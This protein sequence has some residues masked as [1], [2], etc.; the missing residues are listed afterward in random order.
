MLNVYLRDNPVHIIFIVSIIVYE[1]F[2]LAINSYS[3]MK[4]VLKGNP[5][6][7]DALLW[8]VIV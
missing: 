8:N 2:Y 1:R 5:S 7:G 6:P 3:L 4:F